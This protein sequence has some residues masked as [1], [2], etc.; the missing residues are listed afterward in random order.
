[1]KYIKN[2]MMLKY[3]TSLSLYT[4]DISG[5]H[6]KYIVHDI[7][8]LNSLGVIYCVTKKN[9]GWLTEI[10]NKYITI[11]LYGNRN[12]TDTVNEYKSISI[13]NELLTK[14]ILKIKERII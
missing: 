1:M 13:D 8:S 3:L 7:V 12:I 5:N 14:D 2:L 11:E 6:V 9:N 10:S 4:N